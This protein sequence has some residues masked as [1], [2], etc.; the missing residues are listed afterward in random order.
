M[1]PGTT[2]QCL[3]VAILLPTGVAPTDYTS[4]IADDGSSIE[5]TVTLPEAFT[6]PLEL[7]KKWIVTN[8][9]FQTYHPK[10]VGFENALKDMRESV[11]SS[12]RAKARIQLP[13]QVQAHIF[14]SHNLGFKDDSRILYLELKALEESYSVVAKSGSFEF[15]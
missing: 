7:H 4:R 15:F 9:T 3:N 1:E 5:L 10:V 12:V 11:T 6:N 14:A 8:P 13:F 2:V